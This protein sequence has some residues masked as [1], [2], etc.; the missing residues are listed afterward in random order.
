MTR[1]ALAWFARALL[2]VTWSTSGCG[3]ALYASSDASGGLDA[4]DELDATVDRDAPPETPSDAGSLDAP[5][6]LIDAPLPDAPFLFDAPFPD[7]PFPDVTIAFD[8]P[9]P[10]AYLGLDAPLPDVGVDA[11]ADAGPCAHVETSGEAVS[12]PGHVAI[13]TGP[14]TFEAWVRAAPSGGYQ[15]ILGDR[16]GAPGSHR[17]YLFGI[18]SNGQP[19]VQLS[20]TPNHLGCPRVDDATWHHVAVTR[21]A[22]NTVTCFV[23]FVAGAM[24]PATSSRDLPYQ[25]TVLVGED[26]VNRTSPFD[27][28]LYMLRVWLV[29]R[30]GPE[31]AADALTPLAPGSGPLVLEA[32]MDREDG[33]RLSAFVR[34]PTSTG[35]ESGLMTPMASVV[36]GCPP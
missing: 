9:F 25:S 29:A 31:M 4:R 11:R 12:L 13:G 15:Q 19:Y 35:S 14:F 16:T 3:R 7:A 6:E 10:D 22:T 33:G 23:D 21:D 27:G 18:F 24:S 2:L 26:P 34:T 8:A 28:G 17:G 1:P 36:G 5:T 20:D 32:P 30:S